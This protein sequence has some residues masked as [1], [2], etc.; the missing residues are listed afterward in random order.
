MK[1]LVTPT[2]L[3]RN[4]ALI[5]ELSARAELILNTTGKPL[6]EEDLLPLVADIDGYLAG[7]DTITA[8]V[9]ENAPKLK[10]ISRY[11]V[12]Y[13]RVDLEAAGR[14][15]I[16]V[17]NT[18][19]ANT[20]SVADLAFGLMLAVARKI[21]A[22]NADIKAGGWSRGNGK[23]LYRKTLGIIG[24]GAIG[25]AL[26]LRAKGFSMSVIA[27]DPYWDAAW[28]DANGVVAGTLT[29]IAA[30]ADV[31]SLHVPHTPETH[32]IISRE[33]IASMK[34]GVILINTSRGGLIDED[35]AAD[36]VES[37]KIYGMGIDAFDTEPP[38]PHRLYGFDNVIMTPHAGAHTVEAVNNMAAMSVANLFALLE[39]TGA[40]DRCIVNRK[41][42]SSEKGS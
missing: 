20:Q 4:E 31:I 8:R 3:C 35:A 26:A 23:E 16:P 19:G 17:T 28:A 15:G 32:H 34:D 22:M 9:L 27:Y 38:A 30:Q 29:E 13:E 41:Y 5:K 25:K 2:S 1:I 12:G 11:G 14:L 18:P 39:G 36:F 33:L 6:T 10:A 24:L 37:G 21:P 7:L 40:A 42:L